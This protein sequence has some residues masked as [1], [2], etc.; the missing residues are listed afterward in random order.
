MLLFLLRG[1]AIHFRGRRILRGGLLA[2]VTLCLL[3][4]CLTY[5]RGGYPATLLT[6][7]LC[8]LLS[9]RPISSAPKLRDPFPDTSMPLVLGGMLLLLFLVP[10]GGSRRGKSPG[11]VAGQRR[12][13]SRIAPSSTA[14]GFGGAGPSSRQRVPGKAILW[15]EKTRVSSTPP[16]TSPW[17][18]AT[19]TPP[20][21]TAPWTPPKRGCLGSGASPSSPSPSC[22]SPF[23][24]GAS[25][26]TPSAC[27]PAPSGSP[28]LWP[29][30]SPT[31]PPSS[32]SNSSSWP[33]PC[34]SSSD[35]PGFAI[36]TISVPEKEPG[37]FCSSP[38]SWPPP[39][40]SPSTS[41]DASAA[42][43]IPTTGR[44]PPWKSTTPGMGPSSPA[45]PGDASSSSL[46]TPTTTCARNSSP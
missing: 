26:K 37:S 44:N 42:Y 6:L 8:Q 10:A 14:Y 19:P 17:I 27:M 38:L 11:E 30:N 7:G 45:P 31:S 28:S 43:A 3:L 46:P 40:A 5:S 12:P 35:S 20:C 23:L 21:S 13:T 18:V 22:S 16:T 29:T 39:S 15:K 9:L 36:H 32:P 4:L 34:S 2:A 33:P 24:H 41:P 25:S 1:L